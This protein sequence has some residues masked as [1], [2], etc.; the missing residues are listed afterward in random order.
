[1][2]LNPTHDL[3]ELAVVG[4]GIGGWA[5][6]LALA[7]TGAKLKVYEQSAQ[8]TEAGAG[9][10]LGPNAVRLLQAWGM[11][12]DLRDLG[13]AP[14][15]L[16]ARR[17]QDGQ[18]IGMLPMGEAF[19]HRYGAP[20]LTFHRADLH[21]WLMQSA[22]QHAEVQFCPAHRLVQLQTLS[23]GVRLQF[24]HGPVTEAQALVAADGL[25]SVARSMVCGDAPPRPTGHWAYRALLPMA[26]LPPRWR[27]PQ[28]GL[29]LGRRLHVV[30]YPVR[31]GQALNLVVLLESHRAS[32]QDG[33][34]VPRSQDDMQADVRSAFQGSCAE[35]IDLPSSVSS[36]RT[37]AL[38]DRP[39][40]NAAAPMARGRVALLGDAAH[41]MLPYLAQ[42]AAMAMEDAHALANHWQ[43][44]ARRVE[45]RWAQY[46][47]DRW[48]RVARVQRRAKRNG[49]IF[50]ADGVWRFARDTALAIGGARLMDVP[51]LYR[52]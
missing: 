24:E 26:D 50:H 43:Q 38:Y 48:P 12:Q 28:I 39:P 45:Q 30:H 44:S 34:D 42:G 21:A 49:Q 41:P 9:I 7:R 51:W 5:A 4:G 29:W 20:Y 35:L 13:C 40:L 22:L 15:T 23:Q 33:W 16:L 18:P 3:T 17:T 36:W 2:A 46:A 31:G 14:E 10:G 1:M 6:A 19:V 8:V 37:W 25:H 27:A 32:P 11:G 47:Q 52:A